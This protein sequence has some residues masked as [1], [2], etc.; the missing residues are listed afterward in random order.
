MVCFLTLP[1]E[2]IFVL[3]RTLNKIDKKNM[4]EPVFDKQIEEL[5]H[6]AIFGFDGNLFFTSKC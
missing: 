2:F 1:V 3:D 4:A 5:E 6:L